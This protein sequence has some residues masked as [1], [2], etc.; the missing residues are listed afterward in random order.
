MDLEHHGLRPL[1]NLAMNRYLSLTR[2]Y[3]GLAAMPLFIATRAGVRA[4]VVA[5]AM[6]HAA[7][8]EEAASEAQRFLDLAIASLDAEEPRLIAIGGL[9]G[10]GKSTLARQLAADASPVPGAVHLQSDII[11]KRL[12][13][14]SPETRLSDTYYAEDVT[15]RVYGQMRH[16]AAR[17][18]AAGYSVIADAT[19]L[20]P[21]QRRG[22]EEMAAEA[23]APFVGL[24]LHASIQEMERRLEARRGDASDAAV[25]VLHLQLRSNPSDIDWIPV[26]AGP[27]E[28]A[29]FRAAQRAINRRRNVAA[30]A[31]PGRNRGKPDDHLPKLEAGNDPETRPTGTCPK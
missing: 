26:C 16:D 17:A 4:H 6:Q 29:T 3:E 21:V 30:A 23:D 12:A 25:D 19:F 11:R 5:S 1:A 31:R 20:D 27:N 15:Q 9:S 13:G 24:W 28:E 14:V 2:D 18:L 10:T 22:I 7:R 8:P